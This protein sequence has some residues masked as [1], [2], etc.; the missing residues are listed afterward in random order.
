MRRFGLT[1]CLHSVELGLRALAFIAVLADPPDSLDPLNQPA[2]SF[3]VA[4]L[5]G[6]S[7]RAF[8]L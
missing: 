7:S 6:S 4:V 3:S 1:Q 8:V 2:R 5:V